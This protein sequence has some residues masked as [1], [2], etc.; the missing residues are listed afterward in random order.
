M[1]LWVKFYENKCFMK[2]NLY[3]HLIGIYISVTKWRNCLVD[4]DLTLT[5]QKF[6]AQKKLLFK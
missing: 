1:I 6:K 5:L 4:S 3:I 2:T